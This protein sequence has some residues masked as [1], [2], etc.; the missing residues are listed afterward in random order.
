MTSKGCRSSSLEIVVS[1]AHTHQQLDE[2]SSRQ[3]EA[4]RNDV[5]LIKRK[6][7][8]AQSLRLNETPCLRSARADQL[9]ADP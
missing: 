4:L 6:I 7:L 8:P 5:R 3:A 9:A 1:L 2:T